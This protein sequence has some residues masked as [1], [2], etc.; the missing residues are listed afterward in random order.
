M[1]AIAVFLTFLLLV[2]ILASGAWLIHL[3]RCRL[4]FL[5][6]EYRR[7]RIAAVEDTQNFEKQIQDLKLRLES[8]ESRTSDLSQRPPHSINYTQRSQMLRMIRRGDSADQ[9]AHTLGVP[10]SQV[11]LLMKL[12]GLTATKERSVSQSA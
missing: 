9:I 3:G 5:E 4:E 8:V 2:T 1:T 6:A 11:R 10:L 7:I 12:P